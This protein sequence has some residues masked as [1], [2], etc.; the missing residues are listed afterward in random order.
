LELASGLQLFSA[1]KMR[2]VLLCASAL[3][4][5]RFLAACS[6][7]DAQPSGSAGSNSTGGQQTVA[8]SGNSAGSTANGGST[9]FGGA[10]NGGSSGGIATGGT[11]GTMSAGA[12][13]TMSAGAGGTGGSAGGT[14]G[15]GG[16]GGTPTPNTKVVMYLPNWSGSFASWAKKIDFTKMT[17]LNLAFGTVN[18]GTNDWSMGA[19][20]GDVQA[21]AAAAHA[22]NVKILVSIGGADDDIGII[23]RY[24]TESNIDPL[25]ANLDAFVKRLDLDGVDVDL[26]RGADMKS[27]GNFSKFAAKL[28]STLRPE[29]KLVTAALAQYIMEDAGDDATISTWLNAYDF[30][31]LMIYTTNMNTYTSELN[32]WKTNRHIPANK[33]TWGV[34]FSKISADQVKQLTTASKADGGVMVWE[35]SLDSSGQLWKAVQDAI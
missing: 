11:G 33:L 18:S 31:N 17:H 9:S 22:A 24:Q 10:A 35:L 8:G 14:A 27:S 4:A 32:W 29:G 5:A 23:N 21:L 26:E 13:G 7:A 28:V 25:V 3:V 34:E 12:G 2:S 6:G 15:S 16:S 20:D 19:A 1:M 30:I